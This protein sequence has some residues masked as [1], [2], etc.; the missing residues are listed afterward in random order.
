MAA[1]SSVTS[2]DF[3][4]RLHRNLVML[5]AGTEKGDLLLHT[6]EPSSLTKQT[7]YTFDKWYDFLHWCAAVVVNICRI[8]P[9]LAIN[10]LAWQ[11]RPLAIKA[12]DANH[13]NGE[14][15]ELLLAV[16]SEDCSLRILSVNI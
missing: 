13:A 14:S 6:F 11:P 7:T 2:V 3:F 12:D 4:P 16:A 9:S 8:C 10:Q 5:A 1:L 15:T